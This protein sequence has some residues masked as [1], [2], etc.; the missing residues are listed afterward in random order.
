MV[1]FLINFA[2]FTHKWMFLYKPVAV[3]C[4]KINID[5]EKLRQPGDL[6]RE[7]PYFAQQ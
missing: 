7:Y 5:Y 1:P 6:S 3:D 2:K 4:V